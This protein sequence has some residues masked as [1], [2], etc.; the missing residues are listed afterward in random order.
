MTIDVSILPHPPQFNKFMTRNG[1]AAQVAAL[2]AVHW[3]HEYS[4]K[5][6]LTGRIGEAA[7]RWRTDGSW[8]ARGQHG[9]D[10]VEAV[11]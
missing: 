4:D 8:A 6:V 3:S 2:P 11:P 9:N 10:L 7:S 5:F 1:A